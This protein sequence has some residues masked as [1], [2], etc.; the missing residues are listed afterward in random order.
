MDNWEVSVIWIM[1]T[2]Q[3]YE[4]SSIWS[5]RSIYESMVVPSL[6]GSETGL[7]VGEDPILDRFCVQ[8]ARLH[9]EQ[10]PVGPEGIG[11]G[12]VRIQAAGEHFKVVDGSRILVSTGGGHHCQTPPV[13]VLGFMVDQP[14]S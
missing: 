8:E 13:E 3:G 1:G 12:Q 10:K 11:R 2:R 7:S 14:C 6:D 9:S 5:C 4:A